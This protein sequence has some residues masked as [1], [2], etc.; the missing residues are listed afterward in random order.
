MIWQR[1]FFKETFKVFLLLL[2]TFLFLFTFIDLAFNAKNFSDPSTPLSAILL[3]YPCNWCRRAPILLA[4]C[5]L[6]ATV[7]VLTTS[8]QNRELLA[9]MA[10]GISKKRLLLPFFWLACLLSLFL[11][12]NEQWI[13]P[14]A[15]TTLQAITDTYLKKAK[16]QQTHRVNQLEL[17][18][19][20]N[21]VYQS[22]NRA[23][24]TFSD[25]F[26]VR[27]ADDIWHLQSLALEPIPEGMF[28]QH[29]VR[30]E[31]GEML[32]SESYD[33]WIFNDMRFDQALLK[34]ALIPSSEQPLSTLFQLSARAKSNNPLL[35]A[36]IDGTLYSRLAF[37]LLCLLVVLTVA[38]LCLHY[39]RQF[40]LFLIYALSI[41]GYV[42]FY[43][44]LNACTLA[45]VSAVASPLLALGLPMLALFFTGFMLF[46]KKTAA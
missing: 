18:D 28:V 37:P 35:K 8:N 32:L 11:Y 29:L 7:K 12:V 43:T 45:A 34:E 27:S 19:G 30:D 16:Q 31:S 15:I 20:S 1:Y 36:E 26:W 6:I 2:A 38:P 3:Y 44:I 9:L 17:A 25:I 21:L 14:S 4:F 22:Y 33:Q 24:K 46:L 39:D 40:P 41:V 13:K 10:G 42:V 23:S 5:I